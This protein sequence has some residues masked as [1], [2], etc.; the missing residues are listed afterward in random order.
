[1]FARFYGLSDDIRG[2]GRAL[3]TQKYISFVLQD[4]LLHFNVLGF[5]V[6]D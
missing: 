2:R 3:A 1:M 4:D 5:Q 6:S